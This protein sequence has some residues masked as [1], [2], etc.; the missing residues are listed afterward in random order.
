[1]HCSKKQIMRSPMQRWWLGAPLE[2]CPVYSRRLN[3]QMCPIYLVFLA[4]VGEKNWKRKEI[5]PNIDGKCHDPGH[6]FSKGH[7]SLYFPSPSKLNAVHSTIPYSN[8]L[9]MINFFS[10]L[11][12][13]YNWEFWGVAYSTPFRTWRPCYTDTTRHCGLLLKLGPDT[14]LSCHGWGLSKK[15]TIS[16]LS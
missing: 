15:S 1:M 3:L 11:E 4:Y 5:W 9:C 16:T 13:L 8:V 6:D 12:L 7:P 14:I 2:I 10:S